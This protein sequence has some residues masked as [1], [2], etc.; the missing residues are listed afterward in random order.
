MELKY[1]DGTQLQAGA[2]P[3]RFASA[4]E[5]VTPPLSSELL[6]EAAAQVPAPT[7]TVSAPLA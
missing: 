5:V 7:R 3:V 2:V 6:N 4:P 1:E